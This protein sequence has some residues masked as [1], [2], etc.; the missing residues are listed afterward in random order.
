MAKIAVIGAG[1]VGATA[2]YTL[3]ISGL[4]EELAVVDINE[5]LAHG[6]AADIA[7]GMPF[8][9]PVKLRSGGYG[10]ARD[11]DI[12]VMTAGAAQKPGETRRELVGRNLRIMESASRE[13]AHAAPDCVLI[14]VSNPLDVLTEAAARF[15]GF[16]AH[17]VFGSGTVLDTARLKFMLSG[18]TGVDARS[19]DT[20]VLGEHG[21]SEFVAWSLTRIAGMS[22]EEYCRDCGDCGGTLSGQMRE[23]FS[24]EVRDA[25]YAVIEQKGST[26]YAIAL[27]LQR[28]C[29]AV[30]RDE[31]S[32]LTVSTMPDGLYGL[33]DVA[34]SLPCVV[35]RRG[36][37]RVLEVSLS[38][39]ELNRLHS[40][41]EAIRSTWPEMSMA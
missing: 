29:E 16:P 19:I 20:Y 34:L 9:S 5:Q 23:Q 10:E 12:V 7:H 30:L 40:S 1:Q 25:A 15:T 28:I 38:D 31:H 11:A 36:V 32:I 41:A 8:C 18:H 17:R 33:R 26:C 39:D 24:R 21:D 13:I 37:E 27:A 6:V 4:V 35:G 3:A 14:V 22:A 2:A